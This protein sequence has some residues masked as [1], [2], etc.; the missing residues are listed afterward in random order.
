MPLPCL[1]P[2]HA[3]EALKAEIERDITTWLAA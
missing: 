1:F 3:P 2:T